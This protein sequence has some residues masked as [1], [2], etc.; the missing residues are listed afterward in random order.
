MVAGV[1]ANF[2]KKFAKTSL[3]A[4][5]SGSCQNG[6]DRGEQFF[7]GEWFGQKTVDVEAFELDRLVGIHQAAHREDRR[8]GLDRAQGT[9][10]RG[11]VHQRHH[12]VVRGGLHSAGHGNRA[13]GCND[14]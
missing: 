7:G 4:R 8:V 9:D 6:G 1:F 3:S 14:E 5:I 2:R 11:S 12:D 13:D 10:H